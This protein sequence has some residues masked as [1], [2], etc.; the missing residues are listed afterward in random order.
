MF[1]PTLAQRRPSPR[2]AAS[3]TL[4]LGIAT[5]TE[6]ADEPEQEYSYYKDHYVDDDILNEGKARF[7]S[8]ADVVPVFILQVVYGFCDIP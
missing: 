7:D 1:S 2:L 8:V 4:V 6:S 3:K 5:A